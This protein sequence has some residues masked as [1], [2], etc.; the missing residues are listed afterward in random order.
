MKI[1]S[2]KF[3][4]TNTAFQVRK[5]SFKRVQK[6]VQGQSQKQ[7][8]AKDAN[9]DRYVG[10][11]SPWPKRKQISTKTTGDI[12]EKRNLSRSSLPWQWP[13]VQKTVF[14]RTWWMVSHLIFECLL[15]TFS[16]A[17]QT[18]SHLADWKENVI[19]IWNFG[20]LMQDR[21]G[22]Q[23]SGCEPAQNQNKVSLLKMS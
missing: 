21:K 11:G 7:T 2:G 1:P 15:M 9:T 18:V 6:C 17:N 20:L 5:P 8:E 14:R 10:F 13:R 19:K 12:P 23:P 4:P 3:S 16:C 22:K